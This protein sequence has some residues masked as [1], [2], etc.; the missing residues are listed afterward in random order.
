MKSEIEYEIERTKLFIEARE[1]YPDLFIDEVNE[2]VD[3][4]IEFIPNAKMPEPQIC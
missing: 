2:K 4:N 1:N 3:D